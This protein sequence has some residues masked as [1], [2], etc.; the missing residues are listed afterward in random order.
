MTMENI[1]QHTRMD[2]SAKQ[3]QHRYHKR[4]SQDLE[5]TLSYNIPM[6][7][8]FVIDFLR[9]TVM[10]MMADSGTFEWNVIILRESLII[11]RFE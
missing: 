7:H 5:S 4:K 9:F 8:N 2:G 3:Q 1:H 6:D 11:H 10:K